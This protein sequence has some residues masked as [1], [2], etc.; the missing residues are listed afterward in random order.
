[1]PRPRKGEP[2]KSFIARAIEE[3]MREGYSQE[4]AKGR[5]YGFWRTYKK[6][7]K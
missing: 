3:F 5:A 6:R 4:E 7:K 2:R 1:M